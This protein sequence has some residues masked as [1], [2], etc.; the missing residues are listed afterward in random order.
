MRSSFPFAGTRVDLPDLKPRSELFHPTLREMGTRE[1][2]E[3]KR[4]EYREELCTRAEG[5]AVLSPIR[6]VWHVEKRKPSYG[7]SKELP[8][9]RAENKIRSIGEKRS[10]GDWSLSGIQ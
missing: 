6:S 7:P 2:L 9:A 4:G 3:E 8:Q 1:T 5:K 10:D